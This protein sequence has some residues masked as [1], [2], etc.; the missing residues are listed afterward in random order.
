MALFGSDQVID[1]FPGHRIYVGKKTENKLENI[2]VFDL[3]EYSMPMQVTH[4]RTGMLE[5]DLP[6]RRILMHL[7]DVRYQQR[8]QV[9]DLGGD[10]GEVRHGSRPPACDLQTSSLR[11]DAA[12]RSAFFATGTDA[13]RARVLAQSRMASM[14]SFIVTANGTISRAASVTIRLT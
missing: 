4:A 2:L 9:V 11:S 5:T 3:D 12:N 8:D 14:P 6:N 1:Q 7:Y 10:L 13:L